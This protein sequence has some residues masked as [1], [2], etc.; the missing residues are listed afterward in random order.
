MPHKSYLYLI[1]M[2]FPD[3]NRYENCKVSFLDRFTILTLEA[4]VRIFASPAAGTCNTTA[5]LLCDVVVEYRVSS[6]FIKFYQ[7]NPELVCLP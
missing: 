3:V 7:D 5:W 6:S 4:L 1:F 2:F